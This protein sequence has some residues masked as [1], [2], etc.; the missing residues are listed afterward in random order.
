M[1]GFLKGMALLFLIA[2]ATSIVFAEQSVGVHADFL[3]QG[4][5]YRLLS[6]KGLGFEAISR[7]TFRQRNDTP[8][9]YNL[10]GALK[11][12]K[13]MNPGRR[14]RMFLGAGVGLWNVQGKFE[15]SD[16]I[17]YDWESYWQFDNKWGMS[18]AFIVG[19]DWLIFEIGEDNWI[20]VV[21]EVQ[22]GY[23]SRP[24]HSYY[25]D[26]YYGEPYTFVSPG[27]GIGMRYVW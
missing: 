13:I 23:Y 12:L 2:G 25:G 27:V 19:A 8:A 24:G 9:Y 7:F 14:F 20:S 22:F 21:P 18:S 15:D 10:S 3:S 1:S 4:I 6:E 26:G 5:A 11:I 16:H 17:V